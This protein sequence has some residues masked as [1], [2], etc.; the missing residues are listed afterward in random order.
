[1]FDDYFI[2]DFFDSKVFINTNSDVWLF[3]PRIKLPFHAAGISHELILGANF[4]WWNYAS[5]RFTGPESIPGEASA[6]ILQANVVA[7]QQN[8][9]AY[10][11]Y[12]ATFPSK[13]VVT[14]GGRIQWTHNKANDR[15]NPATYAR[16]QQHRTLHAYDAGIR[17]PLGS[18]LSL[19][20]KF[21]R[22]FRIATVDEIYNQFGGPAFDS[23][24]NL[25]EPQTAH[26]G[27]VG[28]E[29]KQ[30]TIRARASIF[31]TNLNNEIGFI[32][33][34]PF[35]F[36]ANLNLPPTRRQGAEIEASWS[37]IKKLDIFGSY[38][39]NDARFRKGTFGGVDVSNNTIPLV[40]RHAASFGSTLKITSKTRLSAIVNYVGKQ[41]YDND[42]ANS[43]FRRM[44]DYVTV[45][46][47]F[48]HQ[49]ANLF[50]SFAV[51]NLSNEKY[52]SYGIRNGA[53]TSFSALPARERNFWFT[54]MYQHK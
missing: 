40:P 10:L 8:K 49:I 33:V 51:K 46:L 38:T 16:D 27:E 7:E 3:N 32:I 30:D 6:N 11:Q 31:R 20:G 47:K 39:F 52:Y 4:E 37:P 9:A 15:F 28:I 44:P 22:S 26:T 19:Y 5:K 14:L 24:I 50:L 12:A 18:A 36:F 29:Y 17:Q 35:V 21:G 42:Q 43:F 54:I 1:M 45:D 25:L 48:T 13:T 23:I 34:N 53:G 41:V 2:G